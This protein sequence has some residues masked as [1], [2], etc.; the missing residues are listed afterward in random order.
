MEES[1]TLQ[2]KLGS[3]RQGARSFRILAVVLQVLGFIVLGGGALR[4]LKLL[5]P[6]SVGTE[7]LGDAF[8][9][10]FGA[11]TYFL[12]AWLARRAADAFVTIA[13]LIREVGEIV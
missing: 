11:F 8:T 2:G 3:I 1:A 6:D 7:V 5:A 13:E 12:L 9:A 10:A 4:L